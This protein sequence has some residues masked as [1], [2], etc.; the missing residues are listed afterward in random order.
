[1][2]EIEQKRIKLIKIKE[3][4]NVVK[5]IQQ[6]CYG[7]SKKKKRTGTCRRQDLGLKASWVVY[8]SLEP[9]V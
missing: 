7:R 6:N 2:E 9:L 4:K 8:F 3:I 1:M 5:E